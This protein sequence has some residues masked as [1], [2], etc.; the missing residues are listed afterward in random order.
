MFVLHVKSFRFRC[1]VVSI[2]I[3]TIAV[4][5]LSV[6]LFVCPSDV[7]IFVHHLVDQ[8]IDQNDH[9][10]DNSSIGRPTDEQIIL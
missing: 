9:L 6:H 4:I 2:S 7:T 3:K 8:F 1:N 10:V 5:R